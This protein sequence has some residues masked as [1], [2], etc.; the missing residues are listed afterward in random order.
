MFC[1]CLLLHAEPRLSLLFGTSVFLEL[2][3]VFKKIFEI[4]IDLRQCTIP[5]FDGVCLPVVDYRRKV[6]PVVT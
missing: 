1:V 5:D 4:Q 6:A 2:L 3:K